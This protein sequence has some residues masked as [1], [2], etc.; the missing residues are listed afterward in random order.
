MTV[1]PISKKG[2][3]SV[4]QP[5]G[6]GH[7]ARSGGVLS[8][9]TLSEIVE[10][11]S[12]PNLSP[13]R[14]ARSFIRH[15]VLAPALLWRT[16]GAE[17]GEPIR[18]QLVNVSRGGVGLLAGTP[19][20]VDQSFLFE[21]TLEGV[22]HIQWRCM[23]RWSIPTEDGIHRIGAMLTDIDIGHTSLDP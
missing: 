11:L 12:R 8:Q 19:F 15:A 7:A 21:M 14:T 20:E 10:R 4:A 6:A 23:A 13:R 9:R 1:S 18:A 17:P 22:G 16:A 3:A 2:D 5:A